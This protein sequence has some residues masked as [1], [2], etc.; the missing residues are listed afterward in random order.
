M[1]SAQ[2][3][4]FA[5]PVD[6]THINFD[7]AVKVWKDVS[8][9]TL[10]KTMDT[11]ALEIV[12][13]QKEN[14]IGRKRLA[15]QTREFKR[16]P[17][18]D[19]KLHSIKGLLRSYQ[20]E[21]DS[22]TRRS[23]RSESVFLNI[24]KLLAEAPD[25]YPLLEVAINQAMQAEESVSARAQCEKLR[26]ENSILRSEVAVLRK[27]EEKTK[28]VEAKVLSLEE[29]METVLIE[30]LQQKENELAAN[31]VNLQRQMTTLRAQ[32]TDLH[33]SNENTEA[34]LADASHRLDQDTVA[35]LLELD[36]VV[37]ELQRA[38]ERVATV[39]RR[40][41]TLRSAVEKAKNDSGETEIVNHLRKH[42]QDLETE[43]G[44]I[45]AINE[46]LKRE[47]L[48][49]EEKYRQQSEG[50]SRD[51]AVANAEILDLRRKLD[52]YDDYDEV[53]RELEILKFVEF[54]NVDAD[55][56][57]LQHVHLPNP[58]PNKSNSQLG[59]S[60]ESLLS[61]SNKR[62]QEDN[63]KLR[64]ANEECQTQNARL[65]LALAKAHDENA[66]QSTLIQK[67]ENDVGQIQNGMPVATGTCENSRFGSEWIDPEDSLHQCSLEDAAKRTS[68]ALQSIRGQP[69]SS[70]LSG[71]QTLARG[72]NT[73]PSESERSILPIVTGQRDRFRQRNAELEEELRKQSSGISD[74]RTEMKTL[75]MDNL[76]LY[77]K[78]RYMQSY[79]ADSPGNG[80]HGLLAQSIGMYQSPS[81]GKVLADQSLVMQS[82][83]GDIGK[84]KDKYEQSMNPFEAFRGREAQR[85]V[86]ALN[87]LERGV[88][89]LTR[90]VVGNKRARNAFILYT[91]VMSIADEFKSR[92]MHMHRAE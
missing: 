81:S 16:L 8:L 91:L 72:N 57:A 53:K 15:E 18:D 29:K 32:L 49:G 86:Y 52:K 9:A 64:V 70:Q 68:S 71:S 62:L 76:Q 44:R 73:A 74:L 56:D 41:E 25:P 69:R 4:P 51:L 78:V 26:Q 22:L 80:Q 1:S 37:A 50:L 33:S 17:D 77:E 54:G 59:H 88:F 38:N 46:S 65:N 27:A 84:Y 87:P 79:R 10:Q 19:T 63:A 35:K 5:D 30:R 3:V 89:A 83:E 20:Q 13:T 75:Q 14:M 34:R 11:T 23:Q 85:A 7:I 39:E 43:V 82:R 67:L 24:Y 90:R 6:S 45:I 48:D 40:N 55:V 60:L 36:F 28:R 2:A 47:K 66:R 21:I 58:N 42:V 12:E 92:T 31:E 61:Q